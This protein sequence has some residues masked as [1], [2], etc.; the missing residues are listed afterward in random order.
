MICKLCRRCKK[1]I[2]HP[3]TYCNDCMKIVEEEKC[4]K[5]KIRQRKYN[6][7]RDPKYLKF[8]KS[9]EWY[10]LKEKKLADDQYRCQ[11]LN[12]NKLAVDVH[13]II[14]IQTPEGWDKRLDYN[15]LESL[16]V[17]HHN[18]RHN[19]FIKREGVKE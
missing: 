6:S 8:Y 1:I 15:N 17:E 5:L 7:N 10:Q 18:F 4:E 2:S 12:C 3:N 19:R 9:K 11:F 16:C 14:P 13:H